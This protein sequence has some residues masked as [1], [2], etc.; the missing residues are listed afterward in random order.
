MIRFIIDVR[1]PEEYATGHVKNALNIPPSEFIERT[2][3]LA[4]I[5][6]DAEVILYCKSG[7]RSNVTKNILE[8]MGYTNVIN[9]INKDH[10]SAKYG[11]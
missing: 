4:T 2:D 9:G 1:E 10:V 7:S 11:F 6:K 5:P 3:K 8:S